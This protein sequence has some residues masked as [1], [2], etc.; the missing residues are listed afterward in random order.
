[1]NILELNEQ[2]IFRRESL[3]E[4]RDM[5]IEPYPAALYNVDAYSTEIKESFDDYLNQNI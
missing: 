5:G 4:L 3:Q 2:E 1:M